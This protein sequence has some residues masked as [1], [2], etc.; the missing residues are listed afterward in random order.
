MSRADTLAREHAKAHERRVRTLR[1]GVELATLQ[2][3][4]SWLTEQGLARLIAN[5]TDPLMWAGAAALAAYVRY[6]QEY[7]QAA[8]GPPPQIPVPAGSSSDSALRIAALAAVVNRTIGL[9]KKRQDTPQRMAATVASVLGGAAT[10]A[11]MKDTH[12]WGRRYLTTDPGVQAYRRVPDSDP[13]FFCAMLASRGFVYRDAEFH[14]VN[15][16]RGGV[17]VLDG[18]HDGCCCT[19]QAGFKGQTL[20]LDPVTELAQDIYEN[21]TG[22]YDGADK[23][24]AFRRAWESRRRQK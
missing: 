18:W 12:D 20:R 3:E 22:P 24:R 8:G 17:A 4:M 5:L 2:A 10:K 15:Q 21:S 14:H 23:A 1:S 13:C 16:A 6:T 9:A 11:A 7:A 19:S